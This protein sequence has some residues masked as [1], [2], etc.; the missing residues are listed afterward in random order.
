MAGRTFLLTMELNKQGRVVGSSRRR[1]G[2]LDF[3]TGMECH[4]FNY[5]VL[6]QID[7]GHGG[8]VGRR[9]H[10]PITIKK[11]VDSSSPKLF[12]A[13]CTN[14]AFKIATLSFNRIDPGGKPIPI[15]RIELTNGFIVAVKPGGKWERPGGMQWERARAMQWEYVTIDYGDIAVDGLPNAMIPPSMLG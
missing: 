1:E 6:T 7:P 5:E 3:S 9:K 8:P 10:S 14:E 2:D 15:R 11:T 12:Q 4:G 13:L